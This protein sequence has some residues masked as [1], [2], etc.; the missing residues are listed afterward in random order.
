MK[1]EARL[2]DLTVQKHK[3]DNFLRD[4]IRIMRYHHVTNLYALPEGE[5]SVEGVDFSGTL[6]RVVDTVK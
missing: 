2:R 4:L 3:M 6:V 5:L 1:E